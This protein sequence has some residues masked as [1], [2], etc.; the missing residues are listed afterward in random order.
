MPEKAI[1]KFKD[2]DD[3]NEILLCLL[4]NSCAQVWTAQASDFG[5]RIVVNYGQ[6]MRYYNNHCMHVK[7]INL[8]ERM[9]NENGAANLAIFSC[10]K[11]VRWTWT[12]TTLSINYKSNPIFDVIWSETSNYLNSYVGRWHLICWFVQSFPA[13]NQGKAA[14]V[15]EARHIFEKIDEPDSAVD[16]AFE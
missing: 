1:E 5:K 10:N 3:P 16:N 11:C 12:W 14:C 15:R 9:K 6:M 4:F 13:T 2:V 8:Y 7:T